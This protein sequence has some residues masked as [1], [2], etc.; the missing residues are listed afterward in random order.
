M[1]VFSFFYL[2]ILGILWLLFL[3]LLA[4]FSFKQKYRHSIKARFFLMRNPPLKEHDIWFH[5]CSF[6][7]I[8]SLKPFLENLENVALTTTT[9]TGFFEA[10][11]FASNVR[12]LPYEIFLPFW[13][14]SPKVLVVSEAEL[15]YM[16]FLITKLKGAKTILINARISDRSY[17]SYKKFSWFYKKIFAN[18]DLVFA[19]SEKDRQRLDE[20]GAKNIQVVGNI[21]TAL[22]PK[23]SKV[24]QKPNKRVITL[25]SSHEGE[26]ELLLK[27]ISLQKNDMLII[28]P[29]HPE[30]F[31]K[32]A[33]LAEIWAKKQGLTCKV[34]SQDGFCDADVLV[35][36]TLGELINLYAITDISILCGSFLPHIGGHNP[37]EPA[38][39]EN[40][41]ISGKHFHNQKALYP[42]VENVHF[43]EAKDLQTLL[44]KDLNPSRV[45]S[46]D[47]I[48]PILDALR[49]ESGKPKEAI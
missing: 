20:L 16:L 23:V 44:D 1:P 29:R 35:C 13:I 22:K 21:K 42:L 41:I 27:H 4:L 38:F 17:G 49:A 46:Q 6:G 10:Q 24:Y 12:Y 31:A 7:E 3:P 36:D 5:A 19:Q 9:Q 39:F 34:F 45:D 40:V 47:S 37:I 32:V 14:K 15:W 28:V 33:N 25:A 8:K 26:E 18:I 11:K 30:R 43:T 48:S 2:L